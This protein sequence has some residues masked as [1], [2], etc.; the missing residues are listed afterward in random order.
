MIPALPGLPTVMYQVFPIPTHSLCHSPLT[1]L[2]AET[3]TVLSAFLFYP[4]R[5]QG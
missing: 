3:L 4:E 5:K 2:P 1:P